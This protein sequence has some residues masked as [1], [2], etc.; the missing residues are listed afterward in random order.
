MKKVLTLIILSL[1]L[2]NCNESESTIQSYNGVNNYHNS[3]NT[4]LNYNYPN[5]PHYEPY[6]IKFNNHY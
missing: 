4:E 5:K 2:A 1:L 3:T 6:K